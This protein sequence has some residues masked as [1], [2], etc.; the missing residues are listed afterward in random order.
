MP[1]PLGRALVGIDMPAEQ[2]VGTAIQRSHALS[3]MPP[4]ENR[5]NR[6][7]TRR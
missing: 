5:D 7:A 6:R 2:D 3:A 4:A 1:L